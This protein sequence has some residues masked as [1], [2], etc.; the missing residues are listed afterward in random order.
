MSIN[1]DKRIRSKMFQTRL[2]HAMGEQGVSQSALARQIGVDRSTISQLLTNTGARL[3]NAQVVAECA[4]ALNVSADWL[5]G[6]S[7]QPESAKTLLETSLEL[8]TAAR[9]LI[10]DQIFD[11]H[12]Q[13]QG[14]KIRH[15]PATL[16]DMLKTNEMLEWEYTAHLGRTTEDAINAARDRLDWMRGSNSD[17][18]IVIAQ[19]ELESMCRSEGYY[20]TLSK[21]VRVQ[22]IERIIELV[23]QLYPRMRVYVY[24]A[25]MLYSSPMT[26]FGP[27]LAV[28]YLGQN[29]M[30]FRDSQRIE[31]FS[32]HFDRVV[33]EARITSRELSAFLRP[34]LIP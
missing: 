17:F 16:P 7:E 14:Y 19:H 32:N 27:Q 9:A 5:L 6:L 20:R 30:A 11:W 12:R 34:F 25:R 24:D 4:H 31:G 3:P 18:E 26:V 2:T 29:Y 22:Q 21:N 33:R 15:A 23:D 13:A 8:T 10:D 28:L 1:I